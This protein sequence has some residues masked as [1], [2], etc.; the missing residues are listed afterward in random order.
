MDA[1][2]LALVSTARNSGSPDIVAPITVMPSGRIWPRISAA[3]VRRT[4][5]IDIRAAGC[6]CVE[7][8]RMWNDVL[9]QPVAGIGPILRKR[10]D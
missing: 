9:D 2:P 7:V 5:H 4:G 10:D 8:R 1:W 3:A 6:K